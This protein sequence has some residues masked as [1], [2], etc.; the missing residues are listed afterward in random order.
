MPDSTAAVPEPE[1][2]LYCTAFTVSACSHWLI[3]LA[4]LRAVT[5]HG[6]ALELRWVT[7]VL[8]SE[9]AWLCRW[10]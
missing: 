9:A 2:D 4:A 6:K 1:G 3:C 8:Q 10:C 5:S 7:S